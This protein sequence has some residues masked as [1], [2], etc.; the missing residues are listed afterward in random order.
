L[1]LLLETAINKYEIN[2]HDGEYVLKEAKKLNNNTITK[3][4]KTHYFNQ[5]PGAVLGVI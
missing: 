2:W 5:T 1:Q 3:I 4:L